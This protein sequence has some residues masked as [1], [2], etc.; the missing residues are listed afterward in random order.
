MGIVARPPI[1]LLV[2]KAGEEMYPPVFATLFPAFSE[3][4][5]F[6]KKATI[7]QAASGKEKQR[8]RTC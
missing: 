8:I 1:R 3:L 4:L 2:A 7:L 5:K 6:A